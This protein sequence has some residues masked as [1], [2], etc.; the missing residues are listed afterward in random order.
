MRSWNRFFRQFQKDIKLWLFCVGLLGLFRVFFIFS[1]REK[2]EPSS[3]IWDVLNVCLFGFRFD[4][5]VAT[6]LILIPFLMSVACGFRDWERAAER[7]RRIAARV[8]VVLSTIFF[9]VNYGFFREFSEQINPIVFQLFND[10]T[11]AILITIWRDYHPVST[12]LAMAVVIFLALLAVKRLIRTGF[13]PEKRTSRFFTTS[14][15]KTLAAIGVLVFMVISIRGTV[16]SMPLDRRILIPTEDEFLNKM[17]L[18]EYFS[19]RYAIKDYKVMTREDKGLNAYLPDRDVLKAAKFASSR[20]E[21]LPDLDGYSL[22]HAAGASGIIPRHIFLIIGESYG[23]W[24]LLDKYRSLGLMENARYFRENGIAIDNFLPASY[25]TMYSLGVLLTGLPDSG[26]FINQQINSLKPYPGA[27]AESFNRMGWKTRFFYGGYPTWQRVSDFALSQGFKETYDATLLTA[28][29]TRDPWGVDDAELFDMVLRAVDDDTH[30]LNVILT[31]NNHTPFSTDVWAK[32]FPLRAVP[33]DIRPAFDNVISLKALGHHWYTDKCIGDFVRRMEKQV[34]LPLFAI[35]G[36]HYGRNFINRTPDLYEKSAVPFILY[37][38]EVVDSI[39]RTVHRAGSHLD[40]P[41]TLIELAAPKGFAYHAL[42]QNLL[43][44]E[45]RSIGIGRGRV[46][47]G[48]CLVDVSATPLKVF[49]L[50]GSRGSD[51]VS[52]VADLKRM[53]DALHGLAWWRVKYGPMFAVGDE[54][55]FSSKK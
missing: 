40:V 46:I 50:P 16:K 33:E 20:N 26:I 22:R 55:K 48:D 35:T 13:I 54:R 36:D 23:S 43:S 32:G 11:D 49:P 27:L 17:I 52:N 2:M 53:H 14:L 51:S 3:G 19:I 18:N 10:D 38:K 28:S 45:G 21:T 7:V 25:L 4:G 34:R 24:P 29:K 5:M 42:G 30:S 39:P 41:P 9:G 1:L 6:Y 12:F 47:T 31:T 15:R 8:F 37:G 44:P